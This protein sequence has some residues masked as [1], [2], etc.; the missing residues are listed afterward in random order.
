MAR[1][2]AALQSLAV[3]IGVMSDPMLTAK[4]QSMVDRVVEGRNIIES[5]M[6]PL[7]QALGRQ[8]TK[9]ELEKIIPNLGEILAARSAL[10]GAVEAIPEVKNLRKIYED[11]G[12]AYDSAKEAGLTGDA[13]KLM[14][15]ELLTKRAEYRA[16]RAK[17]LVETANNPNI[18][19]PETGATNAL[20][21]LMENTKDLQL[22][23]ADDIYELELKQA[24]EVQKLEGLTTPEKI[25]QY[26]V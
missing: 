4:V 13:L 22:K 18:V 8:G 3:D 23:Y 16:L 5:D 24:A 12:L 14:K 25:N 19:M 10:K 26:R 2:K 11:A 17:R 6:K 20:T 9:L 7:Q 21:R 1:S 15:D